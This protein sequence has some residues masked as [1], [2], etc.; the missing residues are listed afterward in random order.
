MWQRFILE[1]YKKYNIFSKNMSL[2]LNHVQ[3]FI[4]W[5]FNIY[6]KW[7]RWRINLG[8]WIWGWIWPKT[9]TQCTIY[10]EYG[11]CWAKHQW[12]AVLY[13]RCTLCKYAYIIIRLKNDMGCLTYCKRKKS[14]WV[15]Q[16]FISVLYSFI[17]ISYF[18]W[19]LSIQTLWPHTFPCD[20]SEGLGP[21]YH[22]LCSD[23]SFIRHVK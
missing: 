19:S 17:Y 7:N 22:C 2:F 23:V 12:I 16:H 14:G 6:R 10:P 20:F 11:Q 8:W 5:I 4:F 15:C 18:S 3:H 21:R 13:Y 9:E 1:K